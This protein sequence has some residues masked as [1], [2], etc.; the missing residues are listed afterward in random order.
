MTEYRDQ[1]TDFTGATDPFALFACWMA[2][3]E[4]TEPDD[5]NA[6]ALATVDGQGQPNMRM[7]LLKGSDQRGFVFY[8]NCQSA[9]GLELAAAPKAALLFY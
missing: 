3:A 2:E 9:K 7:I 8:T 5:P 1:V 4:K 6:M